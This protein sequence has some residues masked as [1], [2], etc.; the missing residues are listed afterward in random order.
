MGAI[1]RILGIGTHGSM[2]TQLNVKDGQLGQLLLDISTKPTVPRSEDKDSFVV[3]NNEAKY[4]AY[5]DDEAVDSISAGS[6]SSYENSPIVP[7]RGKT[8]LWKAK[9]CLCLPFHGG[10]N[11]LSPNIGQSPVQD[12]A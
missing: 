5:S 2:Q 4:L 7:G 3:D 10:I 12:Y 6:P 11:N 9:S 8:C 1:K